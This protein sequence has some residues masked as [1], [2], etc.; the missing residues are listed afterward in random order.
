MPHCT[1]VF[2]FEPVSTSPSISTSISTSTNANT[3]TSTPTDTSIVIHTDTNE[4]STQLILGDDFHSV[5]SLEQ[6]K[7]KYTT[8]KPSS[9][10]YFIVLIRKE[11][12]LRWESVE[13]INILV[14]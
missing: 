4:H 1:D 5:E 6:W 7:R 9:D 3:V 8:K 10:I 13:N 14:K 2:R 12:R 11:E